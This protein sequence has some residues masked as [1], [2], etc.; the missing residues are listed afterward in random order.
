MPR[1][2]HPGVL[3]SLAH[4]VSITAGNNPEDRFTASDLAATFK[5]R[6]IPTGTTAAV[7]IVLLR[8]NTPQAAGLLAAHHLA[9]TAP[10]RDE[11]YVLI[12]DGK[13]LYDI[14]ATS[15]GLYYGRRPSSSSSP[16]SA[17]TPRCKP[18]PSATGPP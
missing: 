16:A 11:G 3:L 9:F 4:G 7:R 13:T 15:S 2:L 10:M 1:E 17:P 6:D 18:P 12:P 8:Q 5:D 14:A